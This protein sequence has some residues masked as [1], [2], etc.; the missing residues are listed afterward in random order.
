MGIAPTALS[1]NIMVGVKRNDWI[2]YDSVFTGTPP[3]SPH[4]TGFKIEVLS[5]KGTN[6]TAKSISIFSDGTQTNSTVTVD[7]ETGGIGL[8]IVPANLSNGDTFYDKDID[9]HITISGIMERSYAG[10]R[11]IVMFA[12]VSKTNAVWYWDKTTGVLVEAGLSK[13]EYTQRVKVAKTN[14]WQSEVF[15]LPFDQTALYLLIIVATATV[16]SGTLLIKSRRNK[17]I[18]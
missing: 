17:P 5:V 15:T 1:V 10:G 8:F 18:K 14:I 3:S 12:F 6:V 2:E 9:A 7:I 4:S 13:D 16:I 11:R